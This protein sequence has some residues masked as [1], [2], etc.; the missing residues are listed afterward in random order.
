M[1]KSALKKTHLSKQSKLAIQSETILYL[2]QAQLKNVAGASGQP[3]C[4]SGNITCD[5]WT[6]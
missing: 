4:T 6:Q 2:N 1:K 5:T 3:G